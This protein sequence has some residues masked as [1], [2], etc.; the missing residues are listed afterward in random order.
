[1]ELV[2]TD[3]EW[4]DIWTHLLR[5]TLEGTTFHIEADNPFLVTLL[6]PQLKGDGLSFLV[7]VDPKIGQVHVPNVT[8]DPTMPLPVGPEESDAFHALLYRSIGSTVSQILLR[9]FLRCDDEDVLSRVLRSGEFE[10][11][12]RWVTGSIANVML[13]DV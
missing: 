10:Q 2:M 5:G 1:M 3:N 13:A 7:E 11:P 6:P 12:V 8:V 9:D 4:Q